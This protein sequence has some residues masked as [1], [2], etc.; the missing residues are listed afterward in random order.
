MQ[1]GPWRAQWTVSTT[2][3]IT[4]RSY[5]ERALATGASPAAI[6]GIDLLTDDGMDYEKATEMMAAAQRSGRDPEE[7]A[8]H[9]IKLRAAIRP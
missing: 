8:R 1:S 9:V 3:E 6:A 7:F 5:Y 2:G 4:R